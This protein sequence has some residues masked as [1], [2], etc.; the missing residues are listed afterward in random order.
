MST[1]RKKQIFKAKIYS[2]EIKWV[3]STVHCINFGCCVHFAVIGPC[4][5]HCFSS[6]HGRG[7]RR[8]FH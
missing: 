5:N 7:A 2:S 1:T 6:H 3:Y 8:N 4:T